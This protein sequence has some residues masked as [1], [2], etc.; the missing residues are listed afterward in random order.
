[1]PKSRKTQASVLNILAAK[2][3]RRPGLAVLVALVLLD[4]VVKHYRYFT[5]DGTF[6]FAAWFGALACFAL[7][8]LA[9]AIGSLLRRPEGTYDD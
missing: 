1:M 8:F 2:D 6:G 3:F 7:I 5:I 9:L 4:L